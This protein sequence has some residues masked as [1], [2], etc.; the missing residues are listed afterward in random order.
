HTPPPCP[1]T[2]S[3]TLHAALPISRTG[4][5]RSLPVHLGRVIA[6]IPGDQRRARGR[7]HRH[8]RVQG[9]HAPAATADVDPADTGGGQPELGLRDRKSTRLNSSHGSNSYAVFC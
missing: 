6:I 9:H 2:S 8:E 4:A 7:A 3:L 1:I 5:E